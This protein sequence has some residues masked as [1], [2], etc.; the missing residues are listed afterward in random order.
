MQAGYVEIIGLWQLSRVFPFNPAGAEDTHVLTNVVSDVYND[1]H[2]GNINVY[3]VLDGLF[4]DWNAPITVN[5]VGLPAEPDWPWIGPPAHQDVVNEV[6]LIAGLAEDPNLPAQPRWGVDC[7]N[8]LLANM[9]IGDI[10]TG[11]FELGNFTALADFR[12][13]NWLPVPGPNV[14]G[15]HRDTHDFGAILFH[16]EDMFWW[17]Y[18]RNGNRVGVSPYINENWATTVGPGLRDGDDLNVDRTGAGV[19]MFNWTPVDCAQ[20]N[21]IY[22]LDDVERLLVKD[23][24]WYNYFNDPWGSNYQTDF[25]VT[26]PSKHY[27]WFFDDWTFW[28]DSDIVAP[29]APEYIA[30]PWVPTAPYAT[31]ADYWNAVQTYRG[32]DAEPDGGALNG[33]IAF[34]FDTVY[35]NGPIS[36]GATVWNVDQDTVAGG[37]PPPGSPW[38]PVAPKPIPHEANIISVGTSTGTGIEE[39]NGL[40]DTTYEMGQ[41]LVGAIT[42]IGQRYNAA[43]P[44]GHILYDPTGAGLGPPYMI[45]PIGVMIYDLNYSGA[46]FRSTMAPWDYIFEFWP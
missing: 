37:E 8:V 18:D 30:Y 9:A 1:G 25:V 2:A 11:Q 43:G 32:I 12:T 28:N 7:G 15:L 39:G 38:V 44:P 14:P 22:S 6:T 36:A 19:V 23:Q 27:H 16:T 21:D 13:E 31:L 24:I 26:F 29:F 41:F 45:P 10:T 42:V 3:D 35:A 40:L 33:S 20:F 4:Y 5:Y 17:P 46:D 34:R